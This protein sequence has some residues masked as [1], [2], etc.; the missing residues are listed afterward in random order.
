[1]ED[2]SESRSL[3]VK[4]SMI[5]HNKTELCLKL[6]VQDQGHLSAKQFLKIKRLLVLT[7]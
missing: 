5:L 4:I 6:W 3:M 2:F 1:M 7:L